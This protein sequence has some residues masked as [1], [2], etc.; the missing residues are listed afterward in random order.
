MITSSAEVCIFG[1]LSTGMPRPLSTTVTT[2]SALMRAT[3]V[4]H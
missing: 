1:C 2:L 3:M 4:S